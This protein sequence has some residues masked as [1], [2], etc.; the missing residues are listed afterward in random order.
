MEDQSP[1]CLVVMGNSMSGAKSIQ[2]IFDL[3]GSMINRECKPKEG[4]I[5]MLSKT[6]KDKNLLKMNRERIWLKFNPKDRISIMQTLREDVAILAKFNLMDY[7]LLL[8]IQDNPAY[9]EAVK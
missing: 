2:G 8:C 9:L 3:K 7:S 1:V 5:F 4:E 6:L